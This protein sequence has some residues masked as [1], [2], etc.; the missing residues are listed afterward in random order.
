MRDCY[1][2]LWEKDPSVLEKQGVPR[3]FCGLCDS[4]KT[5]GHVR[6]FPGIVPYSGSWC[7]AH[8]RR[9]SFVHPLAIPGIFFY[10][11][12]A[13]LL[14]LA[15]NAQEAAPAVEP[16]TRI[17]LI[18]KARDAANG[19]HFCVVGMPTVTENKIGRVTGKHLFRGQ[20]DDGTGKLE[21]FAFGKFP[22]VQAGERVEMC[23]Q[24]HKFKLHRHG[25][26]F[27]DELVVAAMFKGAAIA[28]GRV[29]IGPDGLRTR[30]KAAPGTP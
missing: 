24:Y 28:S 20:L 23:G 2:E 27:H 29:E 15:A 9:L 17:E 10:A 12:L 7:D 8:Y 4:C 21:F 16:I 13:L 5:P 30:K 11:A 14:A 25:V 19:R 26:G 3:G 22:P 6:H 18:L 1:C